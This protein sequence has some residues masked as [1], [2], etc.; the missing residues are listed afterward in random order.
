MF[1]ISQADISFSLSICAS[2]DSHLHPVILI[3]KIFSYKEFFCFRVPLFLIVTLLNKMLVFFFSFQ[4]PPF[5]LKSCT[6]HFIGTLVKP[7]HT[8]TAHISG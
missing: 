3:S 1:L 5:L 2:Y 6:L 7:N 4:P 8:L